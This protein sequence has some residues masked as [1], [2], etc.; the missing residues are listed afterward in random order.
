MKK[1][2]KKEKTRIIHSI[3]KKKKKITEHVTTPQEKNNMYR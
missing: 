3:Q 2:K 1:D